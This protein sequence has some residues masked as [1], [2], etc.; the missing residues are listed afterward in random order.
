MVS[1][2]IPIMHTRIIGPLNNYHAADNGPGPMDINDAPDH[3]ATNDMAVHDNVP[4]VATPAIPMPGLGRG[5]VDEGAKEDR[6]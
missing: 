1:P 3:R 4:V 2:S 6:A 5:D